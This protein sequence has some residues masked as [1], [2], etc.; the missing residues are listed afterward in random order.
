MEIQQIIS[1]E[2]NDSLL[3]KELLCI[4]DEITEDDEYYVC[5]SYMD[6]PDIDGLVYIKA[7]S[8][9]NEQEILNTFKKCKIIDVNY[10]DLIA[11]FEKNN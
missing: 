7:N 6:V 8:E 10:Y 3:E 9:D 4:I 5:R 1:E 2:F 11:E